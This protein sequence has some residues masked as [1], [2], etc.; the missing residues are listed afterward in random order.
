MLDAMRAANLLVLEANHDRDRLLRGPY[1]F[2]L[3][4]RILSQTGHL[5]NEQA[6]DALE[7]IVDD[8]PRWVWLAHLSRTNNTPDLAR[9][10]ITERLKRLGVPSVQADV[11]PPGPGVQ[12]DSTTLWDA[13]PR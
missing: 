2:Y 12:W 9:A 7:A 6:A 13:L 3:K 5:S 10:Q 8:A 1:P 4:K 11:L